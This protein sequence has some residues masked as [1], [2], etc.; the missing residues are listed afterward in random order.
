MDFYGASSATHKYN[1][2][3]HVNMESLAQVQIYGTNVN[4]KSW[5]FLSF[6]AMVDLRKI[7]CPQFTVSY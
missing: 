5:T 4:A 2:H 1:I 7:K 3:V 6:K